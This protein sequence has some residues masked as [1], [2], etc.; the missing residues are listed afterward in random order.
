MKK[1]NRNNLLNPSQNGEMEIK[2]F[3]MNLR[4]NM[5]KMGKDE[6]SGSES[7]QPESKWGDGDKGLRS[8]RDLGDESDD[9]H[10]F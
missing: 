4:R 6:E 9:K 5:I 8:P 1:M 10:D 7:S 2:G 3:A